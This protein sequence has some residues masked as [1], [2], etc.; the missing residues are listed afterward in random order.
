LLSLIDEGIGFAL[1]K[2]D[3][4]KLKILDGFSG[5]GVVSRNLKRYA[6]L[7]YTN[8]LELYSYIINKCYLSN[9]F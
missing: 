6:N 2:L 4:K 5:S 7:L 9:S 1:K 3:K 8:D